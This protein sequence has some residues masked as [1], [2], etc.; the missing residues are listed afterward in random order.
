MTIR[1][2]NKLSSDSNPYKHHISIAHETPHY[3]M[4]T[5]VLHMRNLMLVL[6]SR[7]TASCL[8]QPNQE[9][10]FYDF[11]ILRYRIGYVYCIKVN[12]NLNVIYILR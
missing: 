3:Y 6:T 1:S 10:S 2:V 4:S 11:K 7:L 8:A 12:F 5:L 9:P